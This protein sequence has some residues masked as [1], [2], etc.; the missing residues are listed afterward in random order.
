MVMADFGAEVIKIE[1]EG[2]SSDMYCNRGKKS[3]ACDLK[4]PQA[5]KAI[6][7]LMLT[8]GKCYVTLLRFSF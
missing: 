6:Q 8:A 3:F 7:N 5:A 1:R 4:K 2:N